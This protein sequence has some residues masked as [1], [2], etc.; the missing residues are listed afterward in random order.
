MLDAVI[1]LKIDMEQSIFIQLG[2]HL[3]D[4]TNLEKTGDCAMLTKYSDS[5][6]DDR[7]DLS[8]YMG[9]KYLANPHNHNS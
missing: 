2:I 7:F 8:I 3:S 9:T 1:L 5:D 6:D 4:P